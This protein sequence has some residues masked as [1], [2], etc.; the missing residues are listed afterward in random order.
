[1]KPGKEGEKHGDPAYM[2]SMGLIEVGEDK[3]KAPKSPKIK[4]KK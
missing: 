2:M 4:K 3:D 1:M